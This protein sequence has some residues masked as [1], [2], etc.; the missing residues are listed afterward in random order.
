MLYRPTGKIFRT[1]RQSSHRSKIPD[2]NP[3]FVLSPPHPHSRIVKHLCLS[4]QFPAI[5]FRICIPGFRQ[6]RPGT[7]QLPNG[8]AVCCQQQ[9]PA[10]GHRQYRQQPP[11]PTAGL[12]FTFSFYHIPRL[13]GK[14]P[15][16]SPFQTF[17]RLKNTKKSPSSTLSLPFSLPPPTKKRVSRKT[18]ASLYPCQNSLFLCFFGNSFRQ[19]HV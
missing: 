17:R 18:P 12:R 2:D 4:E 13:T 8:R 9:H 14:I 6:Y 7:L 10:S 3:P 19:F 5:Y 11:Q 1:F 16:F 15:E